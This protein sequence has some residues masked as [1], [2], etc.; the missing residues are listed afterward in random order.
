MNPD[1]F[2]TAYFFSRI[3]VNRVLNHSGKWFEKAGCGFNERIHGFHVNGRSIRGKK[4]G[5]KR[6]GFNEQIDWFLVNDVNG[7]SFREKK[8]SGFKYIL[9]RVDVPY[10]HQYY[11]CVLNMKA[12]MVCYVYLFL[13]LV[14]KVNF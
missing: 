12:K 5:L 13:D 1:I 6:F 7:G 14:R 11:E 8:K 2:E 3:R 9:I 4:R 10:T